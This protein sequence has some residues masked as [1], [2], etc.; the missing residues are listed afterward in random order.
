LGAENM[1]N[2]TNNLCIVRI[3]LDTGQR[4]TSLSIGTA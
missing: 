4:I 3:R 2:A 1:S